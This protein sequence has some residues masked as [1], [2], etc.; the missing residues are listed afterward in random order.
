MENVPSQPTPHDAAPVAR[1][2]YTGPR[3]EAYGRVDELT[4]S[5]PFNIYNDG[6]S[7]YSSVPVPP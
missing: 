2:P 7:G 3:M 6:N 4:R 1:K 5:G